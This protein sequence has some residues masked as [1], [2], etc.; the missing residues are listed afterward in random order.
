MEAQA[1]VIQPRRAAPAD[2]L[3]KGTFGSHLAGQNSPSRADRS[4]AILPTGLPA[5][6]RDALPALISSREGHW[7]HRKSCARSGV[8]VA[9]A[10][11]RATEA[12]RIPRAALDL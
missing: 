10:V 5:S 3:A 9:A 11:R 6:I 12:E 2:R 8:L 4:T 7:S 1:L